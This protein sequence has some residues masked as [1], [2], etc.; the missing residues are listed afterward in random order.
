MQVAIAILAAGLLLTCV[1]S[2]T[3]LYRHPK[4]SPSAIEGEGARESRV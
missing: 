1:A 4:S 2:L 3:F